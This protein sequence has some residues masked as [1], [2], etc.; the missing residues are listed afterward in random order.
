MGVPCRKAARHNDQK[1]LVS[2]GVVMH[3]CQ[4]SSRHIP[5]FRGVDR[6]QEQHMVC[7][8]A[9]AKAPGV[10]ALSGQQL[11]THIVCYVVERKGSSWGQ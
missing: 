3:G 9:T 5:R 7:V 11:G 4:H 10:H 2:V 6:E 8:L 1:P